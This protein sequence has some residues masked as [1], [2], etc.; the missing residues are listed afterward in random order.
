MAQ[1]SF[2]ACVENDT[3]YA[4]NSFSQEKAEVGI[5][6]KAAKA[7]QDALAD[8]IEQR[9]EYYNKCVAAGLI[10]KEKTPEEMAAEA[11]KEAQQAREETAKMRE[12]LESLQDLLTKPKEGE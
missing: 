8:V 12:I 11:L 2:L 10:V 4:I 7:L 6:Q 5:T 3:I 9:D 1:G